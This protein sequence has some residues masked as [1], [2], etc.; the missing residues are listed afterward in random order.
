MLTESL[1]GAA[2]VLLRLVGQNTSIARAI[3][4]A[5]HLV[6]TSFL[7]GAIALTAFTATRAAPRRLSPRTPFDW[8]LLGT[9]GAALVV[10]VTGA[11]TAL[12]DTLYPVETARSVAARIAADQVATASFL[13]RGRIVHPAVAFVSAMFLLAVAWKAPD[14]RPGAEMEVAA[15]RVI[16]L[17]FAQVG[18][19]VMNI[20]LSA[21]G[22]MQVVHLALATCVWLA[23]VLLYATARAS[24][25]T[26][27]RAPV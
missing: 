6:N 7:A 19:G 2:L 11:I 15:H 18:A 23:L 3:V 17:V 5:I 20:W 27:A 26:S 25:E 21:P 8:A 10:S 24:D 1:V 14:A 4:M 16:L 22:W 12:G 13:E 9:L